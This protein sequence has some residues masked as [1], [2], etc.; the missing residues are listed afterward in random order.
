MWLVYFWLAVGLV[1]F[2]RP[3]N[4][5]PVVTQK[6]I[7][8]FLT[9]MNILITWKPFSTMKNLLC[10]EKFPLLLLYQH[11][12]SMDMKIL[13]FSPGSDGSHAAESKK[14]GLLSQTVS[15]SLD[16]TLNE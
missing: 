3:G 14:I 1:L 16:I 11:L 5:V 9:V 13:V 2:Y 12:P 8:F 4:P 6:N 7:Y 10:N 15:V